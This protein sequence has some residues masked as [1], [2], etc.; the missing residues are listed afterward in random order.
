MKENYKE[1]SVVQIRAALT[2]TQNQVNM[3]LVNPENRN[4]STSASSAPTA[5]N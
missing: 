3:R 4:L 5:R 1:E 2:P